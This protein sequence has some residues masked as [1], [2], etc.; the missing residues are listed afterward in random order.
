MW[1]PGLKFF[2]VRFIQSGNC[3]GFSVKTSLAGGFQ[4]QPGAGC[5]DIHDFKHGGAVGT[6][7]FCFPARNI[8]GGNSAHL[9]GDRTQGPVFMLSGDN[10]DAF[11]AVANG[12]NMLVRSLKVPVHLDTPG[13]PDFQTGLFRQL[14]VGLN[15]C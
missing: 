6:L 8:I 4:G 11:R 13:L 5:I 10:I 9:G 7:K 15:S 2:P 1:C 14:Y 3:H 12:I